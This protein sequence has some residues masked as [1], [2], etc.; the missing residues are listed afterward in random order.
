MKNRPIGLT[1]LAFLFMAST[2]TAAAGVPLPRPGY[3]WPQFRGPDSRGIAVGVP[4]PDRWSATHN[5]LWK[6]E[7][8]GRGWSSPVVSADR[9]FLT[10]AISRDELESPKKGLYFGGNR[11]TPPSTEQEWRVLCLKLGSGELLWERT[12]HR[13]EPQSPIHLKNSFAS[14]TPVTDGQRV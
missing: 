13:G 14:E 5:I 9:I 12:V 8:P 6:Q 11:P 2:F 3:A 10:T 7:I 4:H 1:P